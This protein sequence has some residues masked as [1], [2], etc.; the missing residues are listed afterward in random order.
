MKKYSPILKKNS[1]LQEAKT[2]TEISYRVNEY[3]SWSETSEPRGN[4]SSLKLAKN[5]AK[6][7]GEMGE[8]WKITTTYDKKG[9]II[10]Q[11]DDILFYNR[12]DI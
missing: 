4:F 1:I 8:V 12:S 3:D 7:I 9:L 10:D 5:L 6:K 11:E 2:K